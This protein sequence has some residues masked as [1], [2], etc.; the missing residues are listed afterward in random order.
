[1]KSKILIKVLH[2]VH[3][4]AFL[5]E[6]QLVLICQKFIFYKLSRLFQAILGCFTTFFVATQLV[7]YCKSRI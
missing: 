7:F 1:M 6:D 4:V 5:N 2:F 3:L